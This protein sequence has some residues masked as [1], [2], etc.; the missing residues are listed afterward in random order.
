MWTSSC[1]K[2]F[3]SINKEA[4]WQRWSDVNTW[5]EWIPN[6][7]SCRLDKPFASGNSFTLKPKGSPEVTVKLLN[8]KREHTF[9]GCTRFFGATMYDIHEMHQDPQGIRL[10]VTLK[11]MGPL[12]F[13]WRK[14]VAEKI[15][16]N[17]PTLLKNLAGLAGATDYKN[18]LE[19]FKHTPSTDRKPKLHLLTPISPKEKSKTTKRKPKRKLT[20]STTALKKTNAL[21]QS[22]PHDST[23]PNGKVN[24]SM[25]TATQPKLSTTTLKPI[26]KKTKA[27]KPKAKKVSLASKKA[28]T[29]S[30]KAKKASGVK[31][32]AKKTTA[33]K[34]TAK[35]A[36]SRTKS[37]SAK[38]TTAK[39]AT[40]KKATAKKATAKKATAKK[41][42]AKK[43]TAKKRTTAKKAATKTKVKAK[44]KT[45]RPTA[46][47]AKS[48][49][50]A[51]SVSKAKA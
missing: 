33:K 12:G 45:S 22:I 48:R 41:A 29:K 28:K 8:V 14:L 49:S 4:I 44:A 37:A 7:E 43:A 24:S 39:K 36:K 27:K 9:T 26:A 13:L 11:V 46:K 5:H 31:S 20:I 18:P 47:K 15:E 10:T 51:K 30:T 50:K 16:A 23:N 3:K 35:K 25:F 6:I 2:V 19:Q 17:L 21:L 38:K 32:K 40:A 34:T 42:T 1:S